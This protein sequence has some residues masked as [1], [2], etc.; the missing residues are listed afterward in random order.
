MSRRKL[1]LI[2][3]VIFLAHLAGSVI[4]GLNSVSCY[5][6]CI[7]KNRLNDAF[8]FPLTLLPLERISVDPAIVIIA[9]IILNS[10]LVSIIL[11]GVWMAAR[12]LFASSARV[13]AR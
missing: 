3:L 11:I 13:R 7:G 5:A 6:G 9:A 8:S 4:T 1:T 2:W 10:L 12:T